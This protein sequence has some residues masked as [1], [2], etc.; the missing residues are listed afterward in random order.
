MK[1]IQMKLDN[2]K[3][4]LISG[5]V[6]KY[7]FMMIYDERQLVLERQGI[8]KYFNPSNNEQRGQIILQKKSMKAIKK[9][10]D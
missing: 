2:K 8:L 6:K 5:L 4:V 3:D 9:G 7:K 10:C 1:V